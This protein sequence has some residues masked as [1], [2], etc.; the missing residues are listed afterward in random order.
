MDIENMTRREVLDAKLGDEAR[1]IQPRRF[2]IVLRKPLA[3]VNGWSNVLAP[4]SAFKTPG[5]TPGGGL[6]R[7]VS[8]KPDPAVADDAAW[9]SLETP[10]QRPPASRR[11]VTHRRAG[12]R[13]RKGT[14]RA[15][16][17]RTFSLVLRAPHERVN[18]NAVK[19]GDDDANAGGDSLTSRAYGARSQSASAD[20]ADNGGSGGSVNPGDAFD[21]ARDLGYFS[22]AKPGIDVAPAVDTPASDVA[23]I[24]G[25]PSLVPYALTPTEDVEEGTFAHARHGAGSHANE[26]EFDD[27]D[28]FG[29]GGGYD[30]DDADAFFGAT[31]AAAAAKMLVDGGNDPMTDRGEGKRPPLRKLTGIKRPA[32]TPHKR[33]RKRFERRKSLSSAGLR[34]DLMETEDGRPLRRSTRERTKPLEYW[35]GE[36]KKY[37]RVHQSLPTVEVVRTRTPNPAWPLL[38]TPYH[39]HGAGG[40]IVITDHVRDWS[41]KDSRRKKATR[42][43]EEESRRA[44]E[45]ARKR[46]LALADVAHLSDSELEDD[47]CNDEDGPRVESNGEDRGGSRGGVEIV[48]EPEEETPAMAIEPEAAPETETAD[49]TVDEAAAA[50]ENVTPEKEEDEA[51]EKEKDDAPEAP[52]AVPEEAA[53]AVEESAAVDVPEEAM[54][55]PEPFAVDDAATEEV[56]AIPA[57]DV[58]VTAMEEED[59]AAAATLEPAIEPVAEETAAEETTA[60]EPAEENDA[61]AFTRPES[62]ARR[63]TR[64]SARNL[65]DETADALEDA[66]IDEKEDG[67]AEP[68]QA[69]R[70]RAERERAEPERAEP[71]RVEPEP[72]PPRRV[73][74]RSRSASLAS[75]ADADKTMEADDEE[76]EVDLE[77]K[78]VSPPR[79]S[80]RRS[81]RNVNVEVDTE[82]KTVSPKST[83]RRV[84][85][86]SS[87]AASVAGD[88]DETVRVDED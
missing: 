17:A 70:E 13:A 52:V 42:P 38:P 25:R 83:G 8:F 9:R 79:R 84:T 80:T 71:E 39:A 88:L 6:T 72:S 61:A 46:A 20:T 37:S 85:R 29:F 32:G 28:G 5:V 73:T 36:T 67:A 57:P 54:P 64:R 47:D 74:R 27:D 69:E 10:A 30:G 53:P 58:D 56:P 81:A 11:R 82:A 26:P 66:T 15:V 2:E 19:N 60:D 41:Q 23:P 45:E 43:T 75:T 18:R 16:A 7:R 4:K 14:G 21:E 63:V 33:E 48:E 44:G 35:R 22:S 68:E 62:P 78:T 51:P 86:R 76:E 55:A 24:A 12:M 34:D 77:A 40:D 31:P 59:E 1:Q 50:E 3:P 87:R 65:L 49:A